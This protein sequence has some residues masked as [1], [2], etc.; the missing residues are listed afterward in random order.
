MDENVL[1]EA[2]RKGDLE[3]FN[4]LVLDYQDMIYNQSVRIMGD[5]QDA[6]DITQ[7]AFLIAFRKL[8][9]FRGGSFKSWLF[10]ITTNLCYDELRRRKRTRMEPLEPAYRNGEKEGSTTWMKDPAP[11]PEEASERAELSGFLLNE[12]NELPLEM[13][14][15]VVLIDILGLEYGEAAGV[16]RKPIGTVKSR[17]ARARMRLREGIMFAPLESPV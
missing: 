12:L 14:T 2:A 1:I 4:R 3:A 7:D 10:R 15:I 13:R 6:E 16:I 11:S 17:L 9:Y 8:G 5:F